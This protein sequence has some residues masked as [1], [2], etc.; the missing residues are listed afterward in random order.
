[1]TEQM[2]F[3]IDSGYHHSLRVTIIGKS[4]LY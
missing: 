3:K 2:N 1:M 4:A